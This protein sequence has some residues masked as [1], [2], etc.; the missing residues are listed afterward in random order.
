MSTVHRM[1]QLVH[2]LR[3]EQTRHINKANVLT[4]VDDTIPCGLGCRF[5]KVA[6]ALL[7][8]Q[9]THSEL[10]FSARSNWS[11]A[12]TCAV[13]DHS[14][15]F[16]PIASRRT[17]PVIGLHQV[18]ISSHSGCTM[19]T[20]AHAELHLHGE[21]RSQC[22]PDVHFGSLHDGSGTFLAQALRAPDLSMSNCRA[23]LYQQL[24]TRLDRNLV[25]AGASP[26]M[27]TAA[28]LHLM[29]EPN[30][31]IKARVAQEIR[32]LP[33]PFAALHVRRGDKSTEGLKPLALKAYVD[34]LRLRAPHIKSVWLM[35]E[36]PTVIDEASAFPHLSLYYTSTNRSSVPEHLMQPE[37]LHEVTVNA[38]VNL[39]VALNAEVLVG[40]WSSAWTR[41]IAFLAWGKH[42]RPMACSSVDA[43]AAA[44]GNYFGGC[45]DI[46]EMSALCN[47]TARRGWGG[48]I[49]EAG[50]GV[51]LDASSHI[52]LGQCTKALG[53]RSRPHR[54]VPE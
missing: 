13:R 4:F 7:V 14:C 21:D 47:A 51:V 5:S 41:L 31:A 15:F 45:F 42:G 12:G 25:L 38:L 18:S 36:D 48:W 26:C 35:S 52:P 8:A 53:P 2:E 22:P 11:H 24:R 3:Q 34:E 54:Q 33:R 30:E 23:Q 28:A 50:A 39:F 9:A 32:R 37:A 6:L 43:V 29:L 17:A 27:L 19:H 46:R 10:V 1:Q 49:K 40:S 16:E 44:G 20:Q